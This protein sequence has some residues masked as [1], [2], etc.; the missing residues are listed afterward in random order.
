MAH[1]R[2]RRAS[3]YATAID[4][5]ARQFRV[6]GTRRSTTSGVASGAD[7]GCTAAPYRPGDLD[8]FCQYATTSRR[9]S[10]GDQGASLVKLIEKPSQRR[11]TN[12]EAA[13]LLAREKRSSKQVAGAQNRIVLLTDGAVNLGD[14]E[15]DSL[16]KL[17]TQLRDAGIAFDAAGISAADLNDEVLE[18]LTRQGDGR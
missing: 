5:C 8:Q 16:A 17:V 6:D 7:V 13:L 14:A 18:A 15:P 10:H 3:E 11:C 4:D 2:D 12:I 9:E 1:S